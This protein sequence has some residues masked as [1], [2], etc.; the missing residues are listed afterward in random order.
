VWVADPAM[1]QVYELIA[2]VAKSDLAVLVGGETG[3]GKENAAFALH[4]WS[5][6]ADRPIVTLNCAALPETLIESELF[7]YEKG[8]FSGAAAAK[9]GLLEQAD[10][11]R[12]FSTR[13]AS[14]RWSRRPSS[15]GRSSRSA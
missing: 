10:A 3:V 11:G 8:A 15:C 1:L 2:R 5:P 7:G 9:P 13:W 14:C 4:H 12:C 6:R